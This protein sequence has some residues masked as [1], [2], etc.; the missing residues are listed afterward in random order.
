MKFL[1]DYI[2]MLEVQKLNAEVACL[3]FK[4]SSGITISLANSRKSSGQVMPKSINMFLYIND[5][6]EGSSMCELVVALNWAVKRS[7]NNC[8]L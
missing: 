8:L 7:I 6:R 1:D 5:E 2:F 3:L 4:Q